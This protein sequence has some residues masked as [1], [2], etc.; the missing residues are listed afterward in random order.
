MLLAAV[1]GETTQINQT[2]TT[3]PAPSFGLR[4]PDLTVSVD[5]ESDPDNL[6]PHF[7]VETD[8]DYL[9]LNSMVISGHPDFFP[10]TSLRSTTDEA[11]NISSALMRTCDACRERSPHVYQLG[12]ACLNPDCRLFWKTVS[13]AD[14]QMQDLEYNPAFLQLSP[15][16]VEDRVLKPASPDTHSGDATSYS[17]SRG[18]HCATCGRLSCR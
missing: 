5:S 13:G 6:Q 15:A 17:F 11:A 14:L 2:G 18:W 4:Q 16:V 9:N 8:L 3:S 10:D 1:M 12:W 7:K